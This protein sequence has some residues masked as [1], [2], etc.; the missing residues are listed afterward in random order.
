MYTRCAEKQYYIYIHSSVWDAV[1]RLYH[2]LHG[3]HITS[4][5]PIGEGLNLLKA[6]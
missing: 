5:V 4:L 3:F 1:S 2:R 6:L